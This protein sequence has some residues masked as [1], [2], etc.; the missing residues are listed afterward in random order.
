M[1]VYSLIPE[2]ILT[3]LTLQG[4]PLLQAIDRNIQMEPRLSGLNLHTSSTGEEK[5]KGVPPLQCI[6]S[7]LKKLDLV[8]RRYLDF[9]A[10]KKNRMLQH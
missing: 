5:E 3:S 8:L 7:Y 6:M 4:A 1:Q 9:I 10:T 2:F